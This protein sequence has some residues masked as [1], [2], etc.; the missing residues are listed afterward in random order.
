[1]ARKCKIQAFTY[2]DYVDYSASLCRLKAPTYHKSI[3]EKLNIKAYASN[4]YRSIKYTQPLPQAE[5]I[6]GTYICGRLSRHGQLTLKPRSQ[7]NWTK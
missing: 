1:M 4:R 7:T 3:K 5:S 6:R 2:V